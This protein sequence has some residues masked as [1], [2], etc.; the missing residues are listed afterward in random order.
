MLGNGSDLRKTLG[1]QKPVLTALAIGALV[2]GLLISLRAVEITLRGQGESLRWHQALTQLMDY[3]GSAFDRVADRDLDALGLDWSRAE[4]ALVR[5]WYFMDAN[6]TTQAIEY[7]A[8]LDAS[9]N[10]QGLARLPAAAQTIGTFLRMETGYYLFGGVLAALC[11]A[12]FW[13]CLQPGRR[14]PAER[15]NVPAALAASGSLALAVGMVLYLAWR[16]RILPRGADCALF[17]AAALLLGILLGEKR[18]E[19]V[20][21]P[22]LPDSASFTQPTNKPR[23]RAGVS[24]LLLLLCAGFG[25]QSFLH[26]SRLLHARPDRVSPT[27]QAALEAYGLV[28]PDRLILYSPDLLR[29]TRL[30]PDVSAGIPA[31]LVIW[32]GTGTAVPPVGIFSC[33]ASA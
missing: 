2:F 9:A 4:L 33:P 27:R 32:G 5:E 12:C 7:L 18:P 6:I 25:L 21:T 17:P 20:F 13:I 31:N 19:A 30:F 22:S 16:G 29:D 15:R 14:T 3:H 24:A 11:A 10:P 8:Q 28:N 23:L 1:W 26:T